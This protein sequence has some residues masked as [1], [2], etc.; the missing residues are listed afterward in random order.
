VSEAFADVDE[1]QRLDPRMLLVYPVKE[2]I[3]FLPV[4]LGLFIA[5][6]AAGGPGEWWQF[7]GVVLPVSLG[8]LRYLTT[9][10]RIAGGRVELRRGLINRHQLATPLDRVRT[11]DLTASPIHRL[12]GLT[13]IRVGTGTASTDDEDQLDLD[14]VP[15]ERARRLRTDLLRVSPGGPAGRDGRTAGPGADVGSD[16]VVVR[17]DLAW[18]RL[19]PLT[20]SGLAIAAAVLGVS[21][22]VVNAFGGFAFVH[23]EQVL[24]DATAW[25]WWLAVPVAVVALLVVVSLLSVGGYLV[26]NWGF[27]LTHHAPAHAGAGGA[28][29]LS[30]GLLTTHETTLDERRVRGV[31]LSE[32]LGLRLGGGGR[33]AAIV[34]GL[35][36]DE[37]GSSLLVPP[38]PHPVITRV[39]A[40]VLGTSAPVTADLVGHGPRARTRRYTRALG[41]TIALV[42]MAAVLVGT[43]VLPGWPLAT[44]V[45]LLLAAACLGRDRAASLG[46]ALVGRHLVARS[47][48]LGRRRDVLEVD[49]IIGWNLRDTW[50]QRRAGLTTLVATTAGGRQSV[51]VLDVPEDE[52]VAV[53]T[54]A[55]P[56]LMAPFLAERA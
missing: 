25:S 27:T 19:A 47:G 15:L 52:A 41:P 49:A 55:L 50:T 20:S 42:A 11:V 38:A 12:L 1:W 54:A 43:G 34:T 16:R 51:T 23:P 48:S 35:D 7:V 8:V 37:S 46:H 44:G 10:F 5:G 17:L 33:A 14:G 2:L 6:T 3:R 9:S 13:T 18:L 36:R 53:A 30:R 22:Q 40:E 28:W 24:D 39:A 21:S 45:P 31:S 29:H 56:G 4:L 26:T 32:P